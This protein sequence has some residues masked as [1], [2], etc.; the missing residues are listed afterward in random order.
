V[1]IL[2][3]S[4]KMMHLILV[5][6]NDEQMYDQ[7]WPLSEARIA[8]AVLKQFESAH[9]TAVRSSADETFVVNNIA[10]HESN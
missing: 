10:P 7:T 2:N 1:K 5:D 9:L 6:S 3:Q 4:I 8:V